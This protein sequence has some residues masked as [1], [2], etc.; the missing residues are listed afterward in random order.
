MTDRIIEIAETSAFLSFENHLLKIRLSDRQIVSVP[1]GE[2]QCLVLANPALT[3]TGSLLAELANA[4][5]IVVISGSNRMPVSMQ[6]PLEGNYIQT[7]RFHAQTQASQP[8]NKR[9][10]QRIIKEKIKRQ[11][12]LL[13]NLYGDD[14]SLLSW[15]KEVNSGD[16]NNLEGRAAT[17]Y[18]KHIFN[19]R[20]CRDRT[21]SDNNLLL[22]YGYAILRAMTARACCS[23][24]LHPTLGINHHNRYNPYCLADDLMEPYR[25]LVDK[26][27]AELNP[28]NQMICELDKKMRSELLS[29]LLSKVETERG[30]WQLSDLLRISAGQVADSYQ[31]GEVKL[32]YN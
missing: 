24:G 5:V 12:M 22:N 17:V 13:K 18:W 21:L 27:V 3:I 2:I 10:W 16:T 32:Q 29:S 15:S 7:E 9:L 28:A 31:S 8:L 4:G 6:L 26:K 14:F 23:A 11:G 19:D 20:F 25:Y 1:V 30:M